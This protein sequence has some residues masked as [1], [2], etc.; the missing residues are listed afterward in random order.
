MKN[1]FFYF[2]CVR[3]S[4]DKQEKREL[5]TSITF[6]AYFEKDNLREI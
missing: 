2:Y 3:N 5:T 6:I 4:L 1:N